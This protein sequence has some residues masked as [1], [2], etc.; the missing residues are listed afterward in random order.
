VQDKTD[1][2]TISMD[3]LQYYEEAFVKIQDATG[4]SEYPKA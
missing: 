1:S 3:K 2:V 4:I